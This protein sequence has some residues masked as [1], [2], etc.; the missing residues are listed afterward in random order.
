MAISKKL[1]AIVLTMI[2][3]LSMVTGSFAMIPSDAVNSKHEEA[4]ETLGALDIMIGDA[5]TGLFRPDENIKRSEFAKVAVETMGL[6]ELAKSSMGKTKYPDVVEGHWASGYINIA[7]QQGVVIGDDQHN[8]RPDDSITYA[9]AMTILVRIIGHEPAALS[10]GGF[11]NGYVSVGTQNGIAKNAVANDNEPVKRGVVA[12]MTFNSLTVK[13]MEQTGFGSNERYEIVDKTVLTDVL[14]TE[15]L[16]GQIVAIGASSLSGSSN[17]KD[18]EVKIG[19]EIYEVTDRALAK[20]RNLLGFKVTF[21]ARTLDGDEKVVLLARPLKNANDSVTIATD[22]ME[23]AELLE[24]GTTK[25]M[26]WLDK[27]NDKKPLELIIDKDA[28]MIFNGKPISFDVSELTPE[29]GRITVL[30]TNSDDKYDIVFVTSYENYVVED[31]IETSHRVTDKYGKPS[32][33]LD[34]EDDDVKFVITKATQELELSDL[35]EWNVLSVAKSKDASIITIEVSG[36]YVTGKVTEIKNDERGIGGKRYKIAKNYTEEIKLGDEGTFYLDVEGKIAAVDATKTLSSNYAYAV[37]GALSNGFDKVL[38]IKIFDKDGKT[39]TLK[40]G[41]KIKLNGV[42]GKTP[43]DVLE[44]LSDESDVFVPQLITY[45]TNASGELTQ[46]NTATDKTESGEINKS[47][48]TLNVKDSLTY[49]A[50]SKKLGAYNV[51]SETIV[52][53]IPAGKTSTDDF[54]IENISLFEDKTEYDVLIYDLGEDL[55]AKAIIVTN[56]QGI[57]GLED[58]MVIVDYIATMNNDDNEL[59]DKLYG[60]QDGKKVSFETEESGILVNGD[61]ETLKTGDIIQVKTNSKGQIQSIR[62]LFE[63]K[64]KTTEGTEVIA[65]DLQIVYGKVIKKFA[66]SINVSVSGGAVTNYAISGATVY[67]LNTSK[68]TNAIKAV[69]PGDI[70][71]YDELDESR[72]LIRIY[73]DEVKE[74]V[75]VK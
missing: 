64:N 8:F 45:E 42:S 44:K 49:K 61:E 63:A 1:T 21:Y 36:E 2:M 16:T 33:V 53:N 47:S 14:D 22:N 26:Y 67:E 11:P 34:P 10:A 69:T 40:S 30:D 13:M 37:K 29:S 60:Y 65:D 57:A 19:D 70:P 55:T 68:S 12:Q 3:A 25:V 56:S 31:V 46:L 66:S 32:L 43:Q 28:K 24:A 62:V 54:S 7:T 20:I 39:V 59:V 6:G 74:I 72:V 27:E 48:F 23:S 50:A 75:I 4:I 17:L 35:E 38:E 58:S 73:K 52:F 41:E 15:K 5:E 18:N 51:N 9:E 71:Q